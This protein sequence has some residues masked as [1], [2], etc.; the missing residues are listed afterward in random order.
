MPLETIPANLLMIHAGKTKVHG[1]E[2]LDPGEWLTRKIKTCVV[3][4]PSALTFL[5]GLSCA[6]LGFLTRHLRTATTPG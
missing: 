4:L 1:G 3:G 6:G 5:P 2:G